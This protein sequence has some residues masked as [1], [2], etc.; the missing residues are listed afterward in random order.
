[1]DRGEKFIAG[2]IERAGETGL[3]RL[4]TRDGNLPTPN[5]IAAPG[6]WIERINL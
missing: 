1:V 4:W 3:T 6:L 2:V 5:E